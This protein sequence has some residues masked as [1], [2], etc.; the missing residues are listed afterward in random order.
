M[1]KSTASPSAAASKQDKQTPAVV[2]KAALRRMAVRQLEPTP[3]NYARAWREE[4]G[5]DTVEPLTPAAR[6]A[7]QDFVARILPSGAAKEPLMEALASQ[8]W[9]QLSK[10]LPDDVASPAQQAQAWAELIDRLV[11]QLERSGRG[12]TPGRKKEGLQHVLVSARS[13]VARLQQ[14]LKQLVNSWDGDGTGNDVLVELDP[15]AAAAA[16]PPAATAAAATA[17]L[18]MAAAAPAEAVAA[19][20]DAVWHQICAQLSGTLHAALPGGDER[21]LEVGQRLQA[22]TGGFPA[23]RPGEPELGALTEA[24]DE[25]RRV[26]QHRHH[27][28]DLLGSL[29]GELTQGLGDLSEDDS[30]MRGQCEAM[31][32]E[33]DEGLSARGVRAVSDLLRSTRLRQQQVRVERGQAQD[34]LKQLIHRMLQDLGQL[35]DHTGRFNANLGRYVDVI[36]KADSIE[37][38][39]DVVRE[40]VDETRTVHTL[41]SQTTERLQD[42]HTRASTLATRVNELEDELRRLSEEVST[43][44]LTQIANRRG[45]LRHFE[46][47]SGRAG[48]QDVPLSIGILDLDNFKRLNDTLGHQTGDEALKFLARRV[49]EALRPSDTLARY[50]GEEFVVL[51]PDTPVDEGQKVLTR[52][53]RLLSAELFMHEDKQT[54]VTFS[55]GVTLYRAGEPMEAAL[56]RADEALYEA[57][58]NGK[59]RT[60]IG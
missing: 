47:E 10:A 57:K 16:S 31:R 43:D 9:E 49:T 56:Q 34:A 37:G 1:D 18:A 26:M 3:V 44:Q 28:V 35:S 33:L 53:Q 24:C 11:R 60:C 27:L 4:G 14:R 7:L 25:L 23:Q 54:F 22:L 46:T 30:W 55:A 48:R 17:P 8:R 19:T 40:M 38:L 21:A 58:R 29:V 59:N 50:G 36:G 41:V 5:E 13:D 51:L 20:D 52:V 12:W 6:A 42:E 32:S 2:A 45:L 15:A 39:A